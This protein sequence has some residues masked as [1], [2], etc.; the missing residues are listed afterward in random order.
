MCDATV[1]AKTPRLNSFSRPFERRDIESHS[2]LP[3]TRMTK[4]ANHAAR[5]QTRRSRTRTRETASS[6]LVKIVDRSLQVV[7]DGPRRHNLQS[8]RANA[9]HAVGHVE[10]KLHRLAVDRHAL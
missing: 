5:P 6:S 2:K 4:R 8:Q 1:T 3:K 10:R 9:Q 7:D